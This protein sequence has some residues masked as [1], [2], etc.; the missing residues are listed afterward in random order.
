M[1]GTASVHAA[2]VETSG[3]HTAAATG[4]CVIGEGRDQQHGYGCR[5]DEKLTQ[6]L[7]TPSS[8]EESRG[9]LRIAPLNRRFSPKP[10]VRELRAL[11]LHQTSR[12]HLRERTVPPPPTP[13]ASGS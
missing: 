8:R 10:R 12:S 7:R 6:H 5:S 3:V 1:H 13:H 2:A 9:R 11:D 4:E